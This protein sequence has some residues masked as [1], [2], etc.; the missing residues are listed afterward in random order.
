[1]CVGAQKVRLET[2]MS[3]TF[4]LVAYFYTHTAIF[5]IQSPSTTF[6]PSSCRCPGQNWS[7][8]TAMFGT[9]GMLCSLCGT[10]HWVVSFLTRGPTS[11]VSGDTA[12]QT[13][14]TTLNCTYCIYRLWMTFLSAFHWGEHLWSW[15]LEV[16]MSTL[17]ITA[18]PSCKQTGGCG[19]V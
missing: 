1:M 16:P 5:P 8:V 12:L 3:K 10:S 19:D 14:H 17:I 9:F 18:S 13:A 11:G 4:E 2:T 15:Q 6:Q 7:H